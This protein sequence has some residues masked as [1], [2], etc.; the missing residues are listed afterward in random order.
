MR[1][2]FFGNEAKFKCLRTVLLEKLIVT[3]LVKK[4]PAF[5]GIRR[6]ITVFTQDH[7]TGPSPESDVFIPHPHTMFL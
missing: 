3:Q 1:S 2:K 4:F 7:A 5:Y 6:F